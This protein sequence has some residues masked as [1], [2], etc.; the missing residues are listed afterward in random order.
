M[1]GPI[2]FRNLVAAMRLAALAVLLTASVPTPAAA[3]DPETPAARA[4]APLRIVFSAVV[5]LPDTEPIGNPQIYTVNED[6]TDFRRLT[7]DDNLAYD[8]PVWAMGGSRILYTVQAPAEQP[9]L[10]DAEGIYL[11]DADGSGVQ[12]ILAT[13]G[14]VSQPKISPNGRT[15]LFTA[16]WPEFPVVA[17]YT[18]ELDTLRVQNLTAVSTPELG[19]D[20]DVRWSPHGERIL[21][22][23]GPVEAGVVAEPRIYQVDADGGN[24]RALTNDAYWY[25]DPMFSPD[26]RLVAV[27]S[28]RGQ[29]FP[30]PPETRGRYP[31]PYDWHLVVL[32]PAT[33]GERVLTQGK[34]CALR[35][36]AA[37][38]CPA[39]EAPAWIPVWTPDGARI[40]YISVRRFDLTGIYA[41]NADGSNARPVIETP[42]L[43]IIWHDWASPPD[44]L[45]AATAGRIGAD[46]PSSRLLYGAAVY[47]TRVDMGGNV[48]PDTESSDIR[49]AVF[50]ASPDRWQSSELTIPEGLGF[51]TSARWTPRRDAI[52]LTARAPISAPA[53]ETRVRVVVPRGAPVRDSESDEALALAEEQV[54]LFPVDGGGEARQLTT[55]WIEDA[56]DG[57]P[58]G[59]LRANV[60]PDLA[61]DGR[62]LVFA[63]VS[64]TRNESWILRL[65]LITG[66]VVNLSSFTCGRTACY[67][68]GPRYS[69]DG[70]R[71]VFASSVGGTM[72]L[73]VMEADGR[74]V[75]RLT[76]DDRDNVDPAWSQ[77]QRTIVFVR[78][79]HSRNAQA[80]NAL[81]LGQPA[82]SGSGSIEGTPEPW[83]I[84]VLDLAAE[85]VRVIAQGDGW[86]RP[87]PVWS[88]GGSQIAFVTS[89][90]NGAPDIHVMDANGG[91]PRP[92][93]WTTPTWELF[94]DWR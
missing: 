68:R 25:T 6:G 28:Y 80:R 71:I 70:S 69:P 82:E 85:A 13:R 93:Q 35:M 47:P 7:Q 62:F 91:G 2:A 58:A 54:F 92:L 24:R 83:E 21:F 67:D 73:F 86:P 37:E 87:R 27:S 49:R 36:P 26:G 77:D 45:V 4:P 20:T 65:D 50:S 56:L 14:R 74:N 42:N 22:V 38:P 51:P 88:P 10:R 15:V 79:P 39:E 11:M 33:G 64:A 75:R 3:Q 66:D 12:R 8:W 18:V 34:P 57:L 55:P 19:L 41:I 43:G 32:D 40:A 60:E 89:S 76:R 53:D 94:F 44:A 72:Q 1:T 84:A 29:D 61:P 46:V 78:S 5:R 63:N 52:L 90:S 81:E 9:S 23:S 16:S 17:M 48:W 59:D 31:I 30:F